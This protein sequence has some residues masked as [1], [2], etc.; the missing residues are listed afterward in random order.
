MQRP[1]AFLAWVALIALCLPACTSHSKKI[2]IYASSAIKVDDTQK[3]ITVTEGTTHHEQELT[4]QGSDPVTLNITSPTG[5]FTLDAKEDGLYIANIKT[6][7]VVGSYQHVGAEGGE[8][9]I[10]QDVLLQK[11]D[12]LQKLAVGANVN[13]ANR[14]YFIPPGQIAKITGEMKAKIFGP[15]TTIPGAFDAGSVPELYKFYSNKELREIIARLTKMTIGPK[16]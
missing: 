1:S 16:Q 5:K 10:S 11:V 15:F 12:S 2:I 4:F 8:A 13:A 7:T 9:K 14:N 6:D 3:N